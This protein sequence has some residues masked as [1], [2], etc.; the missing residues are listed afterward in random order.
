MSYKQKTI[1]R[2]LSRNENNIATLEPN[3]AAK[4]RELV[5]LVWQRHGILLL[6]YS[7]YRSPE[8]QAEL[9]A[10]YLNGG[11]LAAPPLLSFHN[12]RLAVD[13]VPLKFDGSADWKSKHWDKVGAIGEEVGLNWG[14]SFGDKPHFENRDF[15]TVA[16]LKA[17]GGIKYAQEKA[18][19][20]VQVAKRNPI[21]TAAI[22]GGTIL[23]SYVLYKSIYGRD[24]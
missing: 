21:K 2:T 1:E 12:Y 18:G 17:Q 16:Q 14:K 23:I 3:T 15:G 8:E 5:R 24:S 20:L 4:V 22:I 9:Y 7:A 11:A 13:V 19:E 10:T 6:I